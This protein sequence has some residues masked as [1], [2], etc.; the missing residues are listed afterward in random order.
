MRGIAR[1]WDF[2]SGVISGRTTCVFWSNGRL[3]SLEPE[4]S[5]ENL[6]L[7]ASQGVARSLFP[8][9]GL[10]LSQNLFAPALLRR[11]ARPFGREVGIDAKLKY[12]RSARV[13]LFEVDIAVRVVGP[14]VPLYALPEAVE[15]AGNLESVREH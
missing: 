14:D 15:V 9:R 10:E 12:E 4:G 8:K 7:R 5:P 3:V 11:P 2:T 6:L 13:H 1:C